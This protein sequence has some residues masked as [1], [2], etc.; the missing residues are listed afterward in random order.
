MHD[1]FF[2]VQLARR[3]VEGEGIP[4]AGKEPQAEASPV[5][6]GV[7]KSGILRASTTLDPVRAAAYRY[8]QE[9]GTRAYDQLVRRL[10]DE[11][12]PAD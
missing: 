3:R 6:L 10:F 8:Q 11:L 4:A 5:K 9:H 2:R 12:F 7:F 1:Q